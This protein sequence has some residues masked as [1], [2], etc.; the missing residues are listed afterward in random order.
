MSKRK[1]FRLFSSCE[2]CLVKRWKSRKIQNLQKKSIFIYLFFFFIFLKADFFNTK[3]FEFFFCSK[4]LKNHL[5]MIFKQKKIFF[6]AEIFFFWLE[7]FWIFW[8]I[9]TILAELP[10]F[11]RPPNQSGPK[12]KPMKITLMGIF[13][14]LAGDYRSL[15]LGVLE[16]PWGLQNPQR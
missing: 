5:K 7:I 1:N 12:K 11:L 13:D 6:V 8:P 15:S 2:I 14:K 3:K 4:S 10:V 9:F 16:Y